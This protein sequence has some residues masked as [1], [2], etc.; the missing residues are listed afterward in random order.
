VYRRIL[1]CY[2]G[3]AE[4]RRA[5]RAGADLASAMHAE[6]FL[7]AI[8]RSIVA[9]A[10]PEAVTSA[11]VD[12][13]DGTARALLDD[14][15]ARLRARG[16]E[17]RGELAVGNALEVIPATARKL[18]ADLVVLAHRRRGRLARWWTDSPEQ[19]LLDLLSCSILVATGD[20]SDAD[21]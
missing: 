13:E 20:R 12:C 21:E 17:A 16:I 9:G 7:L 6:A 8:C 18:G 14:G 3:T 15:V 4:G 2:D 11:L 10:T 1:L 19:S 5:L